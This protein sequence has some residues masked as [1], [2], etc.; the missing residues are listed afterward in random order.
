M[1]HIVGKEEW[2]Y[3]MKDSGGPCAIMEILKQ[4]SFPLLLL[5]AQHMLYAGR[6]DTQMHCN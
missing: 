6:L 2:R 1:A 3:S 5:S 4:S